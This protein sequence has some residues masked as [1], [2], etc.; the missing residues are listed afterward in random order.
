[1]SDYADGRGRT[2]ADRIAAVRRGGPPVTSEQRDEARRLMNALLG[3][4]QSFGIGLD[5][6]DWVVDLP[7]VCVDVVLADA[8]KRGAR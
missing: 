4:G 6:F 3:A 2:T 1:M 5:D 8:R 7:G